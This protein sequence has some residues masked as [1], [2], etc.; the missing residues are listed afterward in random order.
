MRLRGDRRE[1]EDA[2]DHRVDP[3]R[4]DVLVVVRLDA[5]TDEHAERRRLVLGGRVG[6]E[7]TREL[8]IAAERAVLL[9]LEGEL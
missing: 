4:E 3:Q 9:E 1:S 7:D 5:R 8:D 6:V 2:L